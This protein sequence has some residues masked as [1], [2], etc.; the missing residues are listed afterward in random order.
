MF[1]KLDIDPENSLDNTT[2]AGAVVTTS[3]NRITI[4]GTEGKR[5]LRLTRNEPAGQSQEND[6]VHSRKYPSSPR[7][8]YYVFFVIVIHANFFK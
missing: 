2:A 4:P 3:T 5:N 8:L 6:V 1:V 7:W